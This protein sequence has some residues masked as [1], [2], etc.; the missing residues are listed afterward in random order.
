MTRTA[1]RSKRERPTMAELRSQRAANENLVSIINGLEA[2]VAEKDLIIE[3]VH[4][5]LKEARQRHDDLKVTQD[6]VAAKF[7]AYVTETAEAVSKIKQLEARCAEMQ[8]RLAKE[9]AMPKCSIET[10][11]RYG[12]VERIG[13]YEQAIYVN[14]RRELLK[15]APVREYLKCAGQQEV[16]RRPSAVMTVLRLWWSRLAF[17]ALS[18]V[19]T[20]PVPVSGCAS[21]ATVKQSPIGP[22]VIPTPPA[23]E[24]HH[25]EI[26]I[27]E[28]LKP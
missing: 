25:A 27:E 7:S 18:P 2:R 6:E 16:S 14:S 3:Q 4:Q 22:V 9:L 19:I 28:F 1:K 5:D 10:T 23:G 24:A 11:A 13:D 8:E 15:L 21:G 26:N 17:R 20:D 12:F